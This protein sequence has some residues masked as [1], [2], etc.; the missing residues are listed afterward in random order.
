MPFCYRPLPFMIFSPP[1]KKG[2]KISLLLPSKGNSTSKRDYFPENNSK[3]F[4]LATWGLCGHTWSCKFN[5]QKLPSP[6]FL[7]LFLYIAN[8]SDDL[9]YA[10]HIWI[11][12]SY[13]TCC[14]QTWWS[15]PEDAKTKRKISN[16]FPNFIHIYTCPVCIVLRIYYSIYDF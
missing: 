1:L 7:L 13:T 11:L 16:F 3:I 5:R 4:S 8:I 9:V 6:L 15:W 2:I 10:S 14:S 12:N